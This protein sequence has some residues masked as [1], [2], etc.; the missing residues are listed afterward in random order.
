MAK[1]DLRARPIFHRTRDAIEAHLT[2]VFAA[3]AVTRWLERATGWSIKKL[4]KTLRR[5]HTIQ[6]QVGDQ[7][8]TAADPLPD[9]ALAA[10][11]K[12]RAAAA[13]H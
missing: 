3:L 1:S 11:T 9:D 6:I 8:I 5:Y 12:I 13:T 2:V 10:I 4:V 7:T